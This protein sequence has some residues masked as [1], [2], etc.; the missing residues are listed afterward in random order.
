MDVT[1]EERHS[2]IVW[3]WEKKVAKREK[4][5]GSAKQEGDLKGRVVE[6]QKGLSASFGLRPSHQV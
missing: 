5:S 1:V 6:T 3:G 4:E 2:R